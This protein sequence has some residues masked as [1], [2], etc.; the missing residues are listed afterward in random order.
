MQRLFDP[1]ADSQRNEDGTIIYQLEEK[2]LKDFN[3]N[4]EA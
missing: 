1:F 4:D 2:E 3:L